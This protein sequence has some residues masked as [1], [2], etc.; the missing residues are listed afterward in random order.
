M[1]M[2]SKSD[3]NPATGQSYATN[4]S[5]GQW[6]DNYWA[7]VVEPQLKSQFGG[8]GGGGGGGG[9]APDYTQIAQQMLQMRQ[10]ANEPAIASLRAT[11][12]TTQAG[13]AQ[14]ETA[15]TGQREPLKQRYQ[16]ILDELTR[17]ETR[18]TEATSTRLSREFG[19]RG[20]PLSSGYFGQ[21]LAQAQRPTQEFYAGQLKDVGLGQ[22]ESERSLE[23]LISGLPIEREAATNQINQAIAQLQAGGAGESITNALSLFQ[24]MQADK[25]NSAQLA[26]NQ[27]QQSAQQLLAQQAESRQATRDPIEL[28]LLQAQLK[29]A[30]APATTP[31]NP[32]GQFNRGIIP[33]PKPTS[34]PTTS[35]YSR[36]TA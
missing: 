12:P 6:D 11:I 33:E 1:G 27:Q 8:A 36:Y 2:P 35:T 3:I 28:A 17:R 5:T 26:L 14:K 4:P 29:K 22:A 25:Q 9:G 19:Q 16:S 34:K 30:Q 10:Q 31:Y 21:D 23:S 24:Q 13:Y 7:N 18:E 32:F 15:L 20:I